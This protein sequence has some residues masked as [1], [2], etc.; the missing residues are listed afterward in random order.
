MNNNAESIRPLLENAQKRWL[1]I[2]VIGA[3]L[4][5]VGSLTNAEQFF[6]SYLFGY[7]FW[8]N[9]TLGCLAGVMAHNL[10]GGDWGEATRR[11]LEAGMRVLPLMA[12]LVLPILFGLP[13]IYEWAN[14]EHV[15]HSVIL[16][17]KIGFLNPTFFIIRIGIYFLIWI[18]LANFLYK[19][20]GELDRDPNLSIM[21]R[22]E[23]LSGPGIVIYFLTSTLASF[24]LVMSLE[25]QWYSTIYGLLFIVY[26]ALAML[27]VMIGVTTWLSKHEPLSSV[28]TEKH[29]H[30]LGKLTHGFVVFWIYGTFSQFLIMW[31]G[32]L[33][34]EIV[35]YVRRTAGG[36]KA[37]AIFL[38]FFH[39]VVPF[40]LLLSR[41]NKMR[42]NSLVKIAGLIL[43]MRF[44]DL[45]WLI[46]PAFYPDGVH[47]HW[48]DVAAPVGIGGLWLT[49]F[50]AQLKKRPLVPLPDP[51]TEA[52]QALEHA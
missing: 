5:V 48:L 40:F 44:V 24:D 31:S 42:K 6:R 47:F 9:L 18:T 46:S 23:N 4:C 35:W 1:T 2:G 49:T 3:V 22:M 7:M 25:P 28:A 27:T 15:A 39:F 52:E 16:Q 45:Y 32:N 43:F 37:V 20:S 21:R 26:Q 36:W 50:Y 8:F 11:Q 17:Q 13:K 19:W 38:V 30:D 12:L 34:E 14:P 33:P 10:T 51:F 29:F 41:N